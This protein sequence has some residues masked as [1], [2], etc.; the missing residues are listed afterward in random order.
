MVWG[1]ETP[2][3]QNIF[4]VQTICQLSAVDENSIPALKINILYD[5][6]ESIP[7]LVPTQFQE[8][9]F[10]PI[11]YPKITTQSS[12]HPYFLGI[13]QLNLHFPTPHTLTPQVNLLQKF[14]DDSAPNSLVFLIP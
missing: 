8:L 9:I 10:L 12:V 6:A 7:H 13:Y 2:V 3:G 4:N 1:K 14:N 5:I 11:T